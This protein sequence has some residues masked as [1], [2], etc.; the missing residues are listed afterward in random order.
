MV[1]DGE[2][3]GMIDEGSNGYINNSDCM[4]VNETIGLFGINWVLR[5]CYVWAELVLC[6]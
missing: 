4:D 6:L 5:K 3:R 1:I 2:D